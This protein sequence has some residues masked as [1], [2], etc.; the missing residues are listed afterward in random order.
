QQ[1][2][3]LARPL[4]TARQGA[5]E[6]AAV[7]RSRLRQ[8]LP[9]RGFVLF[10]PPIQ[11]LMQLQ[12]DLLTLTQPGGLSPMCPSQTVCEDAA[13]LLLQLSVLPGPDDFRRLLTQGVDRLLP[14]Q[15]AMPGLQ[16]QVQRQPGLGAPLP[17]APLLQLVK[18]LLALAI[19]AQQRPAVLQLD[20]LMVQAQVGV[21][22]QGDALAVLGETDEQ[23]GCGTAIVHMPRGLQRLSMLDTVKVGRVSIPISG[24]VL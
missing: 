18:R 23:R 14:A 8:Q 11:R 9:C 3:S 15:L 20:T 6:P 4:A 19:G 24:V 17:P 2:T 10:D 5:F 22:G 1:A 7:Q 16:R 21:I 13:L 12:D